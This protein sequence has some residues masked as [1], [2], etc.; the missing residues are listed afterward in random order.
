MRHLSILLLGLLALPIYASV[1]VD[2][3]SAEVVLDENDTD[4][5]KAA[6]TM[7][8]QQVIVKASGNKNALEN[9]VITK[10]LRKSGQYLS[11]ISYGDQFGL[12]SLKMVFN[13]PQIQSLL[14][15]ANLPY[16]VDTRSNL[17]VWMVEES[18][19]GRE[20]LWE[21]SGESAMNQ[22]KYFADIR[23]LPVTIP[24]GDIDDVTG[25]TA[26]DL[27]GG[28]V[29]PI[30]VASQRYPGDAVLV[31]RIQKTS[32]SSNIRWTLYDEKP[33]FMLASN[34]EP[35]T[36]I[37]NGN[38]HQALEALIDEVSSFYASKSSIKSTGEL[39]DTI[40][41]Q[42]IN[43]TSANDFFALESLLKKENSVAS[44]T[45]LKI[46][47]DEVTIRI[48]LLS[49]REEFEA[50]VVQNAHVQKFVGE[51]FEV[52][53]LQEAPPLEDSINTGSLVV[54][55]YSSTAELGTSNTS[56]AVEPVQ[57]AAEAWSPS[58]DLEQSHSQPL[59][60][61]QPVEAEPIEKP[62]VFEWI[63]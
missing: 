50:E 12:K 43:V 14:T 60:S 35:Q 20:I 28:F 32:N 44:I 25:I 36:G 62:I 31:V 33:K 23:G 47:G 1:K 27:W 57:A 15:Q 59:G 10:A 41:T 9:P 34:K 61:E 52:P 54:P 48:N 53:P 7:G 45:V 51:I 16:W 11:Q 46:V 6:R 30:S 58:V 38:T 39:T 17:V 18:R 5:E 26:P 55:E 56:A 19:Y 22:L 8:L 2:V 40:V 42:F 21:Q 63:K 3:F 24:V 49:S 13:P 4:T 37:V 29:D